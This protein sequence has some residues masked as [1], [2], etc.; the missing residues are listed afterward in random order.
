VPPLVGLRVLLVDDDR[1]TLEML[2]SLLGGKGAG[3]T[4]AASAGEALGVLEFER[5]DVIVA[6]IAMPGEDGYALI[7]KVRSLGAGRGGQTP[8]VALTAYAGEGDRAQAL[9]AGFQA[10]LTKP[11]EPGAFV[12]LVANLA[13][14][15]APSEL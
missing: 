9:R 12:E 6:D 4:T 13:G 10:Y 3:V 14:R 5:P 8:A 2:A 11:V 7:R 1:D 15:V